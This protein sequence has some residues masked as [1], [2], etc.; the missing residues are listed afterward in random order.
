MKTQLNV[1]T[2]AVLGLS[3]VF[4]AG[5]RADEPA[6]AKPTQEA[7]VTADQALK[8][9]KDGN[10]RF[11][12][13][14]PKEAEL[15]SK[16]RIEL[17]QGQRPIAVVL[18]CADSRAAPEIV[19]DKGLGTLFVIRVAGNVGGPEVYASIE[20]ALAELK[21]PLV[22]VLGHTSCGAVG[23]ALKGKEQPSDN[24]K[25]L[26]S[27]I[28][29]GSDLAKDKDAALDGAIRNN[30][31]YQTQLLTRRSTI[32]KDFAAN[33]RVTIL[34]AVYDL[35]TGVVNWLELPKK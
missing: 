11:V 22:V 26:V 15:G 8:R 19:F 3:F 31:L 16:K 29:T 10:A 32:I 18:T 4:V 9:L 17:A 28:H 7:T 1:A 25:K 14:N 6:K 34:P 23:A 24:L 27:L 2:L 12:N 20:Y 35:K 33:G 21:T 30:V 13:D 5:L